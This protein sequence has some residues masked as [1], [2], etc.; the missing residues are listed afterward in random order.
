[1]GYNLSLHFDIKFL[2]MKLL[3]FF[4]RINKIIF[5]KISITLCTII[6]TVFLIYRVTFHSKITLIH[7]YQVILSSRSLLQ[8][9]FLCLFFITLV[10]LCVVS[11]VLK[12]T[13]SHIFIP[14]NH[15]I[16]KKEKKKKCRLI[17]TI[18]VT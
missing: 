17:L 5:L 9:V 2:Q 14:F 8:K 12:E 16:Q 1:M 15:F 13:L 3:D 10:K 6:C 11:P 4:L 7:K 18:C